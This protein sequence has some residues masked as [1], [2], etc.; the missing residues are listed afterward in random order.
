LY[1][2]PALIGICLWEVNVLNWT[3][4]QGFGRGL[5]I[6]LLMPS[7][8]CS[9]AGDGAH[10]TE[11]S[12]QSEAVTLHSLELDV[13]GR[14]CALSVSCHRG[15]ASDSGLDLESPVYDKLVARAARTAAGQVLVV[16]GD[17]GMSFLYQK[18]SQPSPRAGNSMPPGEPLPAEMIDRVRAWI[19]V[20]APND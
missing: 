17:P 19:Q 16:P 18:L 12:A 1:R 11:H 14:S 5:L 4:L 13:F 10:E 2:L 7:A 3:V 15:A 20:G 6:A 9:A 8:G